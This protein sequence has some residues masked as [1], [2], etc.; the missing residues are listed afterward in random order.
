MVVF[1]ELLESVDKRGYVSV[2]KRR[3]FD[4]L[5]QNRVR[6]IIRNFSEEDM[7]DRAMFSGRGG[8]DNLGGGETEGRV[9]YEV[10]S[11]ERETVIV[12][13]KLEVVRSGSKSWSEVV[14]VNKRLIMGR[15][16]NLAFGIRESKAT[17]ELPIEVEG[18][19]IRAEGDIEE[20][21]GNVVITRHTLAGRFLQWC[22]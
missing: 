2:Q 21:G 11:K 13:V 6:G 9:N 8:G 3:G 20:E 16:M 22:E 12:R 4:D 14:K 10:N 18:T 17:N 7:N 19:Y 5:F 1:C 15:M